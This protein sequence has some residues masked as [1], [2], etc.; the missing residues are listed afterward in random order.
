MLIDSSAEISAISTEYRDNITD[1]NKDIPQLPLWGLRIHNA[2]GNKPAKVSRRIP[3]PNLNVNGIIG[4]NFWE[5]NRPSINFNNQ[6]LIITINCI[7]SSILLKNT[8]DGPPAQLRAVHKPVQRT[9]SIKP[10]TC[11]TCQRTRIL[12]Y[13][14]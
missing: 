7:E 2:I 1:D 14:D 4:S 12:G 9:S 5:A 6:N 3:V 10:T 8:Q 13:T 11:L